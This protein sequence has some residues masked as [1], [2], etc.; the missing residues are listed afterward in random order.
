MGLQFP[1]SS[2]APAYTAPE[3]TTGTSVTD[4]CCIPGGVE[5]APLLS[6]SGSDDSTSGGQ[7][8]TFAGFIPPTAH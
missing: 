7:T 4:P 2:K 1:K 8:G 5:T 6:N 3:F